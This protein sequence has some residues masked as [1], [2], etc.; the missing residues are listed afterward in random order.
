MSVCPI[1]RAPCT[2]PRCLAGG[3]QDSNGEPLLMRCITCRG[4]FNE[5]AADRGQCP[6]CAEPPAGGAK[7]QIG[8][9]DV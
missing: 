8:P 9:V 7:V 5:D 6:D 4:L 1:D 2:D 3:C